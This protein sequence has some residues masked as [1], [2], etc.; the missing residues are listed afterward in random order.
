MHD[1]LREPRDVDTR[2]E[3]RG[4]KRTPMPTLLSLQALAGNQAVLTLLSAPVA[5]RCGPVPCDCSAE[6]RAAKRG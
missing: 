6:E 4:G 5:Q 1:Q 2:L 3:P